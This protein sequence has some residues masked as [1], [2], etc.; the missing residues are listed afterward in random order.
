MIGPVHAATPPIM[1]PNQPAESATQP[2]TAVSKTIRVRCY[3]YLTMWEQNRRWLYLNEEDKNMYCRTCVE[4]DKGTRSNAFRDGCSSFRIEIIKSHETSDQHKNAVISEAVSNLPPRARPMERILINMEESDKA[5]MI[6]LFKTVY[7][8]C[9]L[10][11]PFTDFEK[12]INFLKSID[13]KVSETYANDKQCRAFMDYIAEDIKSNMKK[14]YDKQFFAILS[15]GSTDK[16]NTQ[17]EIIYI[18]FIQEGL[19]VTRFLT[20]KSVTKANAENL[21]KALTD[22]MTGTMDQPQWKETLVACCFDG[23]NVMMG[24]ISGV[25]VRLQRDLP[26][27]TVIHCCAHRLE[28][29]IK[30]VL[31][32]CDN[33][34]AMETLLYSIYKHYKYSALN[35]G[36]LQN[37][38]AALNIKVRKPVNNKGTRWLAHHS[39]AVEVFMI[40]YSSMITHMTHVTATV[41]GDRYERTAQLLGELQM[42]SVPMFLNFLSLY[43]PIV[44]RLSE[45]FQ[46]PELTIGEVQNRLTAVYTN[47]VNYKNNPEKLKKVIVKD[48]AIEGNKIMY[49]GAEVQLPR[50]GRSRQ[51]PQKEFDETVK[52]VLKEATTIFNLTQQYMGERFK[53]LI[54]DE[55]LP[56]TSIFQPLNWPHNVQDLASYGEDSVK[57]IF[58]HYLG[59]LTAAGKSEAKALVQWTELKICITTYLR[60][61]SQKVKI[62]ALWQHFILKDQVQQQFPDILALVQICLL[63]PTNTADCERGFSLMGRIKNDWRARLNTS[64]LASLKAISLHEQT[65]EQFLPENAIKEWWASSKNK[66]RPH[67]KP[68]GPRTSLSES[69]AWHSDSDESDLD[70]VE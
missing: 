1:T 42:P 33:M 9:R 35:W 70:V 8:L 27:L 23:A 30:D 14:L 66:R 51:A 16:S 22:T 24:D 38:G 21:T 56:H 34:N 32:R 46:S 7:H 15:D 12:E 59:P 45:S 48:M 3:K 44:S 49:S 68:Y 25:G 61:H 67:T 58:Q 13:V 29:S 31:K 65:Q 40:N 64:T 36:E 26:H 69:T 63:I 50:K 47:I 28:L 57:C 60:S 19:P 37:V 4:Y 6:I 11:R 41:T 17:Q 2:E 43:L 54:E 18:R 20:M 39:R 5:Q 62:S 53:D 10:G 52:E 55:V